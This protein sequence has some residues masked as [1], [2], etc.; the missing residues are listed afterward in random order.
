MR[1]N[2]YLTLATVILSVLAVQTPV[3]GQAPRFGFG[4]NV[5][6]STQSPPIGI[7][8]DARLSI[9]I[10]PDFSIAGGS[11]VH[12]YV[13]KGRENASYFVTPS[14]SAIVTMDATNVRSP[15]II[16]GIGGYLPVR[17]ED[18]KDDGGPAIHGGIGWTVL[19]QATAVYLEVTPTL[20]I[21]R[22]SAGVLLPVRFGIVL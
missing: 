18:R 22:T 12:G 20:V 2:G 21:A 14:L 17:S 9:P 19:L 5:V 10:N 13:F 4:L 16:A 7:G 11:G 1:F 15:Y 8:F 3:Q 6:G